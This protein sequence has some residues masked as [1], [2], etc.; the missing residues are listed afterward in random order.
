MYLFLKFKL[1]QGKLEEFEDLW[2]EENR[3]F[4]GYLFIFYHQKTV[5]K[6]TGYA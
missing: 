2:M 5:K 6:Q 3:A 1:T 4:R